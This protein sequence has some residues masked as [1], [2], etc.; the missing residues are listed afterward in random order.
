M[1]SED[2]YKYYDGGE[3]DGELPEK[4]MDADTAATPEEFEKKKKE[5]RYLIK[6][7]LLK[8]LL[9]FALI[10]FGAYTIMISANPYREDAQA[11]RDAL[12]AA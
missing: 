4:I 3:E 12:E 9:I 11:E 5:Q 6:T 10:C 8:W 2:Q 1:K 7:N